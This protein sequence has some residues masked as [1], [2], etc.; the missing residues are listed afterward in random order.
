M[1]D[2]PHGD[3]PFHGEDPAHVEDPSHGEDLAHGAIFPMGR[4]LPMGKIF[5]QDLGLKFVFV[6]VSLVSAQYPDYTSRG[7]LTVALL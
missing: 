7:R 6:V 3:D 2:V 4:I 5:P 1:E